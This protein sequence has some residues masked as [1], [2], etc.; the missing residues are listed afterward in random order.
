MATTTLE[1]LAE[2]REEAE[3]AA[4]WYRERDPQASMGFVREL[5]S[6]LARIS[7]APVR[8]PQYE[9]DTRRI[10]VAGFPYAIVYRVIDQRIV[11]V[12]VAH[13]SRRP[14]FLRHR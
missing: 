4:T 6:A 3:A 2:A 10:L 12:A 11:V 1:F 13:T 14:D 5:R 7:D 9:G 8:W